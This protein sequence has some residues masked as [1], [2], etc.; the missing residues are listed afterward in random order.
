MGALKEVDLGRKLK[1]SD[2]N[3]Q[4]EALQFK[5]LRLQRA[6]FQLG[7]RV[8]CLLEGWDAAGKGGAIQRLTEAM[9]PRG[10]V[11]HAIGAPTAEELAHNYLWRFW[12]R[13]PRSGQ[14]VIFDRSWYGRVLVERVEGFATRREWRQAY[15]EINDFERLLR[16]DGTTLLKFFVHIS[17]EEQ[18]RR[19]EDRRDDPLKT[20]KLTEDDWRNREK[21]PAYEEA[22]NEMVKRTSTKHAPWTMIAGEDKRW[23]RIQVLRAVAEQLDADL[24]FDSDEQ[25]LLTLN[26]KHA[27][28]QIEAGILSSKAVEAV[29]EEEAKVRAL[30]ERGD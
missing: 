7:H 5:L 25:G 30:V 14:I 16:Q 3:E 18:L 24:P 4:L 2:Y 23:A 21:W 9:D 8:V 20:W 27:Q 15:D 28:E 17:P 26:R 1:K 12:S 19:Y 29:L 22:V 13:M 6:V 11:V 10:Y